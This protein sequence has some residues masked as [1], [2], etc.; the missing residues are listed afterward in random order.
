LAD[1]SVPL[2]T[3][4]CWQRIENILSLKHWKNTVGH[5]YEF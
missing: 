5:I 4:A 2:Y 3:S 1:P